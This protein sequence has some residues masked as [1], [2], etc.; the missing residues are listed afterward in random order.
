MTKDFEAQLIWFTKRLLQIRITEIRGYSLPIPFKL[1][2]IKR[3]EVKKNNEFI[4]SR[5]IPPKEHL[6]DMIKEMTG[7]YVKHSENKNTKKEDIKLEYK[8]NIAIID[9]IETDLLLLFLT[10]RLKTQNSLFETGQHNKLF[11]NGIDTGIVLSA[12]EQS[13]FAE[14]RS[15]KNSDGTLLYNDI[16]EICAIHKGSQDRQ[17]VFRSRNRTND[18]KHQVSR[19]A[20]SDLLKRIKEAEVLDIESEKII[21]TDRGK[22]YKLLI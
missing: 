1:S 9:G 14:L 4:F 2:E 20:I 3:C 12:A 18:K 10:K 5:D 7:F 15:L 17:T 6:E 22:G 13:I 16:F 11:L 21:Y 19:S 8:N